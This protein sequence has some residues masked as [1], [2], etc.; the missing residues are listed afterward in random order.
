MSYKIKISEKL[1]RKLARIPKRDKIHIEEKIGLLSFDPRP[2]DCKKLQGNKRPPLYR[3][4]SGNYRIIYTIE[5]KKLIIL[6]VDIGHR[7]DIYN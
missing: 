4:R 2:N 1:E 3:V 6:I 5:D 7:K